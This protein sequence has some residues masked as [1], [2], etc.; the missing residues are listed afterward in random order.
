MKHGSLVRATC[1][2]VVRRTT[3]FCDLLGI[4]IPPSVPLLPTL[5]A[6]DHLPL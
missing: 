3:C 4:H 5:S 1:F 2:M 6:S